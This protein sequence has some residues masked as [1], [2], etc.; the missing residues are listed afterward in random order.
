MRLLAGAEG[1]MVVTHLLEEG[2]ADQAVD[3]RDEDSLALLGLGQLDRVASCIECILRPDSSVGNG[4]RAL[5]CCTM[6]V[7]SRNI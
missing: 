4:V 3:T 6:Y 5:S 1:H 7:R 2:V